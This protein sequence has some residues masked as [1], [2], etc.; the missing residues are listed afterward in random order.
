MRG[1][2]LIAFLIV[3][4]A[5]V[6]ILWDISRRRT[7]SAPSAQNTNGYT[8]PTTASNDATGGYASLQK[9]VDALS[10]AVSAQGT[11]VGAAAGSAVGSTAGAGAGSAVASGETSFAQAIGRPALTDAQIAALERNSAQTGLGAGATAGA[12]ASGAA[13]GFL[14]SLFSVFPAFGKAAAVPLADGTPRDPA[15]G[16]QNI[17]G[18]PFLGGIYRGSDALF[19]GQP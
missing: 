18:V 11:K 2:A 12:N 5:A 19:G 3:G 17:Y 16:R 14:G 1:G 6:Y 15:S 9:Q 7:I 10:L 8:M 13:G 4:G